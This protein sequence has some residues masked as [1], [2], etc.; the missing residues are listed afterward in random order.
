MEN[1]TEQQANNP[2]GVD[3]FSVISLIASILGLVV[4]GLCFENNVFVPLFIIL[5]IASVILPLIAKKH[6]I[7]N[8]KTGK[9]ME[10]VSIIA[11]GFN[12]SFIIS[13]LTSLPFFIGY[14][15]WVVCGIAYKLIK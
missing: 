1:K 15:G 5:G 11:G 13:V 9:W 3:I 4:Y 6:R 7:Q 10:I 12:F 8:N 2:T 14:L